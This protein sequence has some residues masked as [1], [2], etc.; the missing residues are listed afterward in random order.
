MFFRYVVSVKGIEMD[1]KKVKVIQE[2]P[3]PKPITNVWSFHGLTCFYK[4]F[5]KT[6]ST[7]VASLTKI[8]KK[9][10]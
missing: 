3:T 10:A 1:K 4:R 6:F 8:I 7:L 9:S 5:V 2:W